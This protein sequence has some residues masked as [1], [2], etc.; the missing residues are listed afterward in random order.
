[1]YLYKFEFAED[2]KKNP[3][4]KEANQ[5]VDDILT[6]FIESN[7]QPSAAEQL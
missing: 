3:D 5:N 7:C 4:K 2:Y 1:M 6:K